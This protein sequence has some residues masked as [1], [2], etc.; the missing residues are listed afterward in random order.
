MRSGSRSLA[1]SRGE[2]IVRDPLQV[3]RPKYLDW[4]GLLS[5]FLTLAT[6]KTSSEPRQ[7]HEPVERKCSPGQ[8]N[9]LPLAGAWSESEAGKESD[10]VGPTLSKPHHQAEVRNLIFLV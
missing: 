3:N 1:R 2:I 9:C 10:P 4:A 8:P 6:R 5:I 7:T